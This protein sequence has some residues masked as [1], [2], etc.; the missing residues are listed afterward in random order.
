[1]R[2]AVVEI[3]SKSVVKST[4]GLSTKNAWAQY[5]R[6]RF[7]GANLVKACQGE[8]RLTENEARG[9]VYAQASQRTIDKVLDAEGPFKGFGLGLEI[10]AIK[11][12]VKLEQYIEKQAEEARRARAEYEAEER[13]LEALSAS[14]GERRVYARR[15]AR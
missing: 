4:P 9:L 7:R 5:V 12:G 8:W 13:R 11:Q 1:M 6:R 14:L 15:S 10:L 2:A 3:S